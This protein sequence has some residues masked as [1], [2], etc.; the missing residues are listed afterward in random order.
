MDARQSL[1]LMAPLAVA[2]V[3]GGIT[4]CDASNVGSVAT[5]AAFAKEPPDTEP[6]FW[7]GCGEGNTFWR[8]ELCEVETIIDLLRGAHTCGALVEVIRT[9][10]KEYVE[11]SPFAAERFRVPIDPVR[12]VYINAVFDHRMLRLNNVKSL[13]V[14]ELRFYK[15]SI[16]VVTKTLPSATSPCTNET[17][18]DAHHLNYLAKVQ[19]VQL[20][21]EQS[22]PLC[23][24]STFEPTLKGP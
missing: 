21:R 17:L 1:L 23:Q 6:E 11:G 24:F 19:L 22:E 10:L 8:M 13:A 9:R 20:A 2:C 4:G 12:E 16:G 5:S 7:K 18:G 14:Y 15:D 3:A